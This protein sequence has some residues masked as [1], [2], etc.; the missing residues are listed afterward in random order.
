[1]RRDWFLGLGA[2]STLAMLVGIDLLLTSMVQ[3]SL[4]ASRVAV[5]RLQGRR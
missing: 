2:V 5:K 4:L 3:K 1:M